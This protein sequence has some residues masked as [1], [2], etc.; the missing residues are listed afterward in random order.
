MYKKSAYDIIHF[1]SCYP[2][3]SIQ[4]KRFSHPVAI[5]CVHLSHNLPHPP[6]QPPTDFITI[7]SAFLYSFIT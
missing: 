6:M 3:T 1:M 5:P 2:I 7:S 4:A